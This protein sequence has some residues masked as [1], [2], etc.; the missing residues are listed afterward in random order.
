[1]RYI[2]HK[3]DTLKKIA[4]QTYGDS[5]LYLKLASYN[6][7]LDPNKIFVGQVLEIPLKRL[8]LGQD[9]S[10]PNTL[11]IT[12]P[13]G[14]DE[15]ISTFGNIYSYI[16]ADGTI[17]P[18]WEKEQLSIANLP[19]PIPI[20]WERSRSV[21]K[22]LCHSKLVDVFT[23]LFSQIAENGLSKHIVSFGGCY[24]F[25]TKRTSGKPSTHSWG[26]AIDLNP[27][28]NRQ[29]TTGNMHPDIV[30]IFR[31]FGFKWGGDWPGR[32]K[33]PM[34]FQFCTGY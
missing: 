30:D 27:D 7:I 26:I 12:P 14:L 10:K 3:G 15:I 13:N 17:D 19:F 20:S 22:I 2:I 25:R 23:Q 21:Q 32:M 29:G 24:N 1:M 8:L 34:H 18:R 33:D 9:T 31:Q 11:G 5:E 16:R 6:G 4:K 28:D